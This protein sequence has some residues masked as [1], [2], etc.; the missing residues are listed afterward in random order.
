MG[1]SNDLDELMVN[2]PRGSP[3]SVVLADLN[4]NSYSCYVE[5]IEKANICNQASDFTHLDD[6]FSAYKRSSDGSENYNERS[7]AKFPC[8]P[9]LFGPTSIS[10]LNKVKN[11]IV[12][13]PLRLPHG[14]DEFG[15]DTSSST[16][17]NELVFDDEIHEDLNGDNEG[18]ASSYHFPEKVISLVKRGKCTFEGKSMN[19]KNSCNAE[20]VIVVN[21][22]DADEL[23]VMS[24]GGVDEASNDEAYPVTVLVTF[25]HGQDIF[26]ILKHYTTKIQ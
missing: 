2:L 7:V 4:G 8:S 3:N 18:S 10:Q 21:S 17:V 24:G 5:I 11:L 22:N 9:A 14:N 26:N 1:D 19:Q 20:G 12:D 23:F 25:D 6:K 15:C 13:A 16:S